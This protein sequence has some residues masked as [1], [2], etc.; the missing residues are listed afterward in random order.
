MNQYMINPIDLMPFIGGSQSPEGQKR[1]LIQ[2][3]KSEAK[4]LL[5]KGDIE[6]YNLIM[7]KIKKIEGEINNNNK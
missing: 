2:L 6:A 7:E 5:D 4:E 3:Y 1:K